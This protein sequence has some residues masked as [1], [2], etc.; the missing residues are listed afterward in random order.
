MGDEGYVARDEPAPHGLAERAADDQMDLVHRL[1][2][3]P[4]APVVGMKQAVVEGLEVVRAQAAQS[5]A[6]EGGQDVVVDV[7]AVAVVGAGCEH[8]VL[9]GQPPAGQ[10][11]A[12]GQ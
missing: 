5:D 9:A 3:Q 4:G 2:R 8:E 10:K 7:A 1:G 11:G 12:Q 6:P